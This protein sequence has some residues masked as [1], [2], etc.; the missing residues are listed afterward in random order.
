MTFI[1]FIGAESPINCMKYIEEDLGV[2]NRSSI[3]DGVVVL[4]VIFAT[5]LFTFLEII[6]GDMAPISSVWAIALDFFFFWV[7]FVS[8]VL[9]YRK[10]D[11]FVWKHCI[12]SVNSVLP[13]FD[14]ERK[15]DR[16]VLSRTI[17]AVEE[18]DFPGDLVDLIRAKYIEIKS[19]EAQKIRQIKKI[20]EEQAVPSGT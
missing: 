8:G 6:F 19:L 2:N 9:L 16:A 17:D 15:I 4:A 14:P 1:N 7:S 12:D 10:I 18:E 3:K 13:D 11:Q 5:S 20:L